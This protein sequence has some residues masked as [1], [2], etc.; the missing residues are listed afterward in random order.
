ML[1][2]NSLREW[3][4]KDPAMYSIFSSIWILGI[5]EVETIAVVFFPNFFLEISR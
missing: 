1:K 4:E 2:N 5:S 3:N